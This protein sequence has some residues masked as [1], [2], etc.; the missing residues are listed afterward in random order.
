MS[1]RDPRLAPGGIVTVEEHQIHGGL[2]GAV[3]ETL[4]AHCPVPVE[5]VAMPDH[6]GESGPPDELLAKWGLTAPSIVE[7]ARRVLAR[8]AGR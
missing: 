5:M 4:A 8:K 3:A 6:F 7:K 1:S 2:G